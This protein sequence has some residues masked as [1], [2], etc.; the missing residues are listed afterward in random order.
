M[1]LSIVLNSVLAVGVVVM[2]VA[3]LVWAIRTQHRGLPR[4]VAT[5]SGLASPVTTAPAQAQG[6]RRAAAPRYRADRRAGVTA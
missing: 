5:D 1:T 3:P 4:L 6:P 2:V